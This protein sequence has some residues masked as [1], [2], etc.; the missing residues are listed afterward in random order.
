MTSINERVATL[1]SQLANILRAIDSQAAATRDFQRSLERI[2]A[3]VDALG[4]DAT[5]HAVGRAQS[6][7][8]LRPVRR[9]QFLKPGA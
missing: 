2:S 3:N 4:E 5:N 8:R 1:E 6:P 7:T 9:R